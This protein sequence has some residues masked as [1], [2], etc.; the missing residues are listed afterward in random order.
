[1]LR[2]ERPDL[3]DYPLVVAI[4][5]FGAVAAMGSV[6]STIRTLPQL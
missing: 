1:M 6:L 5:A 2:N 4:I 3:I